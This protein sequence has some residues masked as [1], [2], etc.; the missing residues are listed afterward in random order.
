ML[1]QFGGSLKLQYV[2][3]AFAN[4]L[5][6]IGMDHVENRLAD[7]VL[8][9]GCAPQFYGR[10][11]DVSKLARMVNDDRIRRQLNQMA[12]T[13]FTLFQL[14]ADAMALNQSRDLHQ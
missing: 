13:F 4:V 6:I 7:Q 2:V 9:T 11:I 10:G 5:V 12:I 3:N 8:R 14:L 1:R